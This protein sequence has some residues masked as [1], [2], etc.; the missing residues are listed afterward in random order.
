MTSVISQPSRTTLVD[1]LS[2]R[3][4]ATPEQPVYIALADRLDDGDQLKGNIRAPRVAVPLFVEEIDRRV[5]AWPNTVL[6][7]LISVMSLAAVPVP[8]AWA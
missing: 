6:M 8:W 1:V 5:A 4:E 7:T 2:R 3:A